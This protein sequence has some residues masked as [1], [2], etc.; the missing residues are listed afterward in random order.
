MYRLMI[1]ALATIALAACN[2]GQPRI[3]RVAL[4]V[5]PS[6][7]IQD[8]MCFKNQ[9]VP[10]GGESTS[11]LLVE[12]Q[13]VV[14]DGQN[15]DGTEAQFL[16]MGRQQFKLGN[17]PEVDFD[18]LIKSTPGQAAGIFVGQ[19][20]TSDIV[21]LGNGSVVTARTGII[22]VSFQDLGASPVGTMSVDSRYACQAQGG[23]SCPQEANVS[24]PR[25]CKVTM[26]FSARRIDVSRIAGYTEQG[27]SN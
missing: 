10:S 1:A 11:N 6:K 9:Q 14:W 21:S 22:T 16:D 3:Y 18:E 8:S 15:A 17:S 25:N 4:D 26:N 13:W 27:S 23:A 19:R 2:A 5:A 7:N 24:D 20:V 12:Q